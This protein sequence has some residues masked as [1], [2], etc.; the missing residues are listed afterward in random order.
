MK[1]RSQ[2]SKTQRSLLSY[3]NESTRCA[4]RRPKSILTIHFVVTLRHRLLVTLC[5]R[6]GSGSDGGDGGGGSGSGSGSGGGG[7]GGGGG[8]GEWLWGDGW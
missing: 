7:G 8:D 1:G 3:I 5:I 2:D 4:G 6:S